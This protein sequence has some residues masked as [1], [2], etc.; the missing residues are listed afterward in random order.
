MTTTLADNQTGTWNTRQLEEYNRDGYLLIRNLLS[1]EQ[2][3]ELNDAVPPLLQG[4][5]ADGM[6]RVRES[7]GAARSVFLTHRHSPPFK[8]LARNP[9]ILNPVK[10][11]LKNDVYIWHS[12]IN[13]KDA[14]EGAVWLW[15]QDYGYWVKDGVED[16]LVSV[17]VFLDR[18]TLNNGCFMV[19]PGT[20]HTNLPHYSDTKTTSYKQWCVELDSLKETLKEEMIVPMLGN[21]GDVLFFHSNVLHGSGHNMSPLPRKTMILVYNGVDNTP[22][23][24]ENPRPD[25]VVSHD[26]TPIA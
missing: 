20:Q 6:Y 4:D 9:K 11:L 24:I 18:S 26:Y 15:H 1:P 21:P 19:A 14:F 16:R 3:A 7:T 17:M 12:K 2:V 22:V 10:Q 8:E 13:V 23:G 5:D 25:W